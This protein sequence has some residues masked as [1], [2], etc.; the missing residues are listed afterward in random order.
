MLNNQMVNSLFPTFLAK[1]KPGFSPSNLNLRGTGHSS[2]FSNWREKQRTGINRRRKRSHPQQ[3][4]HIA[5][6]L[7]MKNIEKLKNQF[8][9]PWKF[10]S[11]LVPIPR[12]SAPQKSSPAGSRPS[13]D[14]DISGGSKTPQVKTWCLR[15]DFHQQK[16]WYMVIILSVYIY[17]YMY[18]HTHIYNTYIYIYIY[19]YIHI[20]IYMWNSL[21]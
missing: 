15:G 16:C 17:I 4:H 19:I 18:I 2:F 11:H 9:P 7:Y 8:S 13:M 6:A 21:M 14:F 10:P 12:K 20:Q 1:R 3:S 5:V